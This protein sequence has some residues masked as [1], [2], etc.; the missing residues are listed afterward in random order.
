MG[1]PL[2]QTLATD[3]DGDGKT[4]IAVFRRQQASGLFAFHPKTTHCCGRW[5]FCSAIP[6]ST[7]CRD[8]D[9][10]G[11]RISPFTVL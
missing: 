4:D 3:F 7:G 1:V 10:D 9:G 2:D 8:Y 6:T 11:R 5:Y